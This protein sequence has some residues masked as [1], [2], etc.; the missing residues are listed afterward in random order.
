MAVMFI[1]LDRF[2]AV[3][4]TL[5]H[6]AGDAALRVSASR[7]RDCVR[8][9]DTAFRQH[10]GVGITIMSIS[11][12]IP[13]GLLTHCVRFAPASHPANGNTR[14]RPA[15]YGSNRAGLT[16]AGFHQKVSLAHI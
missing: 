1:D 15:R 16:P 12:L 11:E 7:L 6:K 4:D 2:K 14:Y 3:N 8:E 9:E 5:G 10:H 13:H